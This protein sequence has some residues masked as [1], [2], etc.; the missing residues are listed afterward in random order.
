M[1]Q[2]KRSQ[3]SDSLKLLESGEIEILG[4]M[5]FS[6]NATFLV[7][8]VDGQSSF[9]AI[10]KPGRGERGLW[11]F[12]DR[13]FIREIAAYELSEALEWGLIPP[14]I[15]REEGPFGEG[16]LQ[17]FIEADFDLHYFLLFENSD[18]HPQFRK[19]ALFDIISN[20]AD[21]KSGH[22]L[23][24]NE[25]HVWGIDQGLCFHAEPKLRTV[26]WDFA[27]EPIPQPL[28]EEL[29]ARLDQCT[30]ALDGLL[31]P[32]EIEAFRFRALSMVNSRRFPVPD[33]EARCYPWPLI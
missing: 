19:F 10:Y 23:I 9:R 24:D 2:N 1:P 29:G 15:Y 18:L 13:L 12:P 7:N 33:P 26:I 21:R 11:D 14:T 16:S 6:S 17:L 5:P 27:G 31:A 32:E 4:R 8:V 22:L 30:K 28:L 3:S 25:D 20:N